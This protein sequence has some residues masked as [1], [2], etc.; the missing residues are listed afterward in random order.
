MAMTDREQ[1]D[2]RF[3]CAS[4]LNEYGIQ[5]SPDDP[6]TSV[7]YII[8]HERKL[9]HRSNKELTSLIQEAALKINPKVYNFHS[10]EA[11]WSFQLG[12]I[13]RW[14]L[15]ILLVALCIWGGAWHWSNVHYVD[16]ARAIIQASGKS[17]EL[18]KRMKRDSEGSY[19]ID[20]KKAKG[21][22]IHDFD[23]FKILNAEIVRVNLGR[24]N[25]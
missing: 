5:L 21:N 8:H 17:N 13:L 23:E 14:S 1:R 22:S 7:L 18:L 3:Y 15:T 11:A 6:I 20:F 19:H 2:F 24:D 16:R 9:N 25:Q 12:I 10:R 4:L